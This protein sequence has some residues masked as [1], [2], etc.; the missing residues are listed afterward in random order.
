MDLKIS[1]WMRVASNCTL[2]GTFFSVA[3]AAVSTPFTA[4][5]V[6][7]PWLIALKAYST[8]YRRPSGE[9]MVMWRSNPELLPRDIFQLVLR[10]CNAGSVNVSQITRPTHTA[11]FLD[12]QVTAKL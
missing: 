4:T 5:E 1:G 10:L 2:S 7:A 8:W 6:V 9:K 3:T 11:V 12:R